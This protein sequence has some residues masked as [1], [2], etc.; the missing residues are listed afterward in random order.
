[1][2]LRDA[3]GEPLS[4]D[5][6]T[7]VD[8][9]ETALGLF[10]G[11]F[12]DPVAAIDAAIEADPDFVFG[13]CVRAGMHL[14]SSEKGAVPEIRA[15]LEAAEA[16]AHR[17]ND[18]ERGHMAAIRAWLD[19]EFAR[20]VEHYSA[21]LV[22]HPRDL[23]ASQFAH[24]SD[25][26][27]GQSSMLRDRVARVLPHWSESDPDYGYLLGMHAF[28][29]E[30]MG[31]YARAEESGKR[32]VALNPK[33]TWA[34]HAVGHVMEMQGRL[35]EG[36]AWFSERSDDWSPDNGFAFHN[37]WHLSLYLLD[38][39]LT[40]QVLDL[41]DRHIRA[42]P[43]EVAM[44]MVDAAAL[45]WRLHLKGVDVGGRWKELADIYETV[46]EDAYY[47]FNDLHA[48]MAFVG[49]DRRGAASKLLAAMEWRIAAGGTNAMMTRD[50]GLPTTKAIQAFGHGDYGTTVELLLPVR[51]IAHRF[52]G[53]HAQRDVLN[54]TLIEA[55]LRDGQG[56][57]A[58]MLLSERLDLKPTCPFNWTQ[59]ARALD[60]VG[61]KEA[62]TE[63][64][65]KAGALATGAN[66]AIAKRAA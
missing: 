51:Q 50:V 40:D 60:M 9:S 16:L 32:A 20:S 35:E 45:L 33:D 48:M 4:T 29:L 37:W 17:A 55:A 59:S 38:L 39:G 7:A 6:Q 64:R 13:H 36:V 31:D 30:E 21:V 58:R 62:A 57:L 24:L 1:M 8:H 61:A 19:G 44:E 2:A 54:L 3:R 43:S 15:S 12:G 14:V 25:F 28:G 23:A 56:R 10:H 26:L 41:Y 46:A 65:T 5:N 42:E 27:L 18:R 11:F 22:D 66:A 53:S 47:A 49:D 63:A 34:I 52:G